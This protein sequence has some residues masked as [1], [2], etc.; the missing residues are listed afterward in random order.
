VPAPAD[1]RIVLAPGEQADIAPQATLRYD[2]LLTDSRC[3]ARAQCIWA[4]EV[5]LAL[6]FSLAG[7][8]ESFELASAHETSKTVQGFAFELLD[9][10]PCP[11]G[12][13]APKLECA[14]LKAT[15]P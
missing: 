2:K 9:Y 10:G 1:G 11:L 7:T 14:S 12:H 5:R 8:D 13:G 4:G 3:P 15:P 6:N